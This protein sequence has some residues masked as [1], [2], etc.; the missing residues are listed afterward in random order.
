MTLTEPAQ[1]IDITVAPISILKN[2]GT[3]PPI[4]LA[5]QDGDAART[6]RQHIGPELTLA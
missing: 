4:A 6:R 5:E 2:G 1:R 3:E